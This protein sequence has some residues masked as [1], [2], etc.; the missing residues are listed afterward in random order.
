MTTRKQRLARLS[1][2]ERE[3]AA[4]AYAVYRQPWRLLRNRRLRERSRELLTLCEAEHAAIAAARTTYGR[5]SH[6]TPG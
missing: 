2:M 4:N 5:A 6:V 1:G 3:L